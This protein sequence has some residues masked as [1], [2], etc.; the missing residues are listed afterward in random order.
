METAKISANGQIVVP[1]EIRKRLK[2]RK[3]SKLTIIEEENGF[4]VRLLNKKY[5]EELAGT[6]G[7]KGELLKGLLREREL[8]RRREDRKVGRVK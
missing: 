7:T 4:K 8:D 5:F 6:I 2:L 3:G 1:A